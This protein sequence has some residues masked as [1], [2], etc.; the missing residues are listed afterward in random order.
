MDLRARKE[1][2]LQGYDYSEN[3]AFF[4]TACVKDRL[5]LMWVNRGENG[6]NVRNDSELRISYEL[7]T[8]GRIVDKAIKNIPVIYKGVRVEK[9]VIMPNHIH[10]ILSINGS[11]EGNVEAAGEQCSPLQGK[12]RNLQPVTISR[13]MKQV[14]GIVSKENGFSFWQKSFHDHIIR[15]QEEYNE[16]W[17]YID[18]NPTK[19]QEDT[20]YEM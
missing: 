17:D 4:I 10:M 9:Y 14:K 16:I 2:R 7:S 19:W 5:N 3:G 11:G 20:Y 8:A 18:R 12:E 13:I 6:E 1:N 15:S